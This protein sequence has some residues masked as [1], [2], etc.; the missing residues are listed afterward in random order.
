ML[1]RDRIPRP[2]NK[3]ERNRATHAQK[4]FRKDV[5]TFYEV[6]QYGKT[7]RDPK[8][9]TIYCVAAHDRF[10]PESVKAAYLVPKNLESA[11][12]SMLFGGDVNLSDPRNG[13]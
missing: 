3:K 13:N 8:I 4:T 6:V 9:V 1:N 12:L 7:K 5:G 10:P 11:E 2:L